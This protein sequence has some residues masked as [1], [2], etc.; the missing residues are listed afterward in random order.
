MSVAYKKIPSECIASRVLSSSDDAISRS[1]RL[2]FDKKD[3]G[4]CGYYTR[5]NHLGGDSFDLSAYHK[6]TFRVKGESGGEDFEIKMADKKRQETGV[7]GSAGQ[8]GKFLKG[9]VTTEWQEVVIPLKNFGDLN[10]SQMG[11]FT[12]NFNKVGEGTIYIDDLKFHLKG[13]DDHQAFDITSTHQ[14]Q[15]NNHSTQ[16]NQKEISPDELTVPEIHPVIGKEEDSLLIDDFENQ[17]VNLVNGLSMATTG[18]FSRCLASHL[19]DPDNQSY[20][21]ILQLDYDKQNGDW[22]I[23]FNVL[24]VRGENY[25]DLTYFEAVSFKIKGE[26]G[27]EE[28]EIEMSDKYTQDQG[29]PNSAIKIGDLIPEGV[30]TEWQEVS[31]PL[32]KFRNVDLR[33]MGTFSIDFY[34]VGSGTIY[35]DDLRFHRKTENIKTTRESSM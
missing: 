11:T 28:F 22:C 18:S 1:L 31:I 5:L 2:D 21:R 14:T 23:Y 34:K 15:I 10:L 20:G 25:L 35:M 9:G 17:G 29:N 7:S 3:K 33:Y 27:G 4:W 30:T 12:I 32:K 13:P 26:Q 24:N 19:V 8:I 16:S 6:V